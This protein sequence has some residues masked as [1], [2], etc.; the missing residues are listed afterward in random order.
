MTDIYDV[1][2]IETKIL[3]TYSNEDEEFYC[4]IHRFIYP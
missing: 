2:D 1:D 4:D 3:D